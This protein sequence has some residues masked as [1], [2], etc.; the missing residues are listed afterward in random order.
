[1]RKENKLPTIEELIAR[2]KGNRPTTSAI[3]R[4]VWALVEHRNQR[5]GNDKA[6]GILGSALSYLVA[7]ETSVSRSLEGGT[8][9]LRF[10]G[11]DADAAAIERAWDAIVG[12]GEGRGVRN[13]VDIVNGLVADAQADATRGVDSYGDKARALARMTHNPAQILPELERRLRAWT[14]PKGP[15]RFKGGE[16]TTEMIVA[17][18]LGE[19][20]ARRIRKRVSRRK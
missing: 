17:F 11:E 12:G 19:G 8:M 10:T 9:L 13:L 16:Q 7:Q 14:K 15:G 3:E 20:D 18:L 4:A 5:P 6:W 2:A 1:M